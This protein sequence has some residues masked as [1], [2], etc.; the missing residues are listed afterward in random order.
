MAQQNQPARPIG[1]PPDPYDRSP[2]KATA[3]WNTL[4]SYYA[5]NSDL[6]TTESH[7]VVAALTHFKLGTPAGEWDSDQMATALGQTPPDFGNWDP[8]KDKFNKQ[9]VPPE[10][11]NEAIQKLY[12]TP[13]R[14]REFSQWYQE[15]SQY[16]RRANVDDATKMY[17]FRRNV[18]PS[19]HNKIISMTPQ[20]ATLT[21]LVKKAREFDRNWRMYAGPAT[22]TP[23]HGQSP[24]IRELAG[25]TPDTEINATQ[26]RHSPFKQKKGQG[27]LT[28]EER[29]HRMKNNLCLYCGKPGYKAIECNAK[30]NT[31]PGTSL[32]QLEPIQEDN[33]S[34]L[35]LKEDSHINSI[36]IKQKIS[37]KPVRLDK[38]RAFED[39]R[40]DN[41]TYN[42]YAVLGSI[43]D[44]G[45]PIVT[46][47]V[48]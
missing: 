42:Q 39:K 15:W 9:F 12:D 17:V 3:F 37:K 38:P 28:K 23:C 5:I 19:I 24:R 2:E 22:Q 35:S 47:E 36:E 16:A 4:A 6:Y 29:E 8:F 41:P 18:N 44:E 27:R 45:S 10:V 43:K 40:D 14:N 32:R 26:G 46:D 11:Q 21:D 31:R 7:K 1:N 20:P 30:P 34:D 13:M 25:E 48:M 33:G